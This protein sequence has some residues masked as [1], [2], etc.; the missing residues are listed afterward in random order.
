MVNGLRGRLRTIRYSDA[1]LGSIAAALEVD[2]IDADTVRLYRECFD[3][4]AFWLARMEK[5]IRHG[6]PSVSIRLTT[7]LPLSSDGADYDGQHHAAVV[8]GVLCPRDPP[9][10]SASAQRT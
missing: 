10:S 1:D 2:G 8:G 7:A 9:F 4:A 6:K 5:V 3:R